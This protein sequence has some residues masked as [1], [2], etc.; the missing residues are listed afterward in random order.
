MPAETI[1]VKIGGEDITIP[2]VANF[3]TLERIWPSIEAFN[4]APNGIQQV[5]AACALFAMALLETKPELNVAVIKSKLRINA[6]DGTDERP[7]LLEGVDK[8]LMASGLIQP[9][10]AEPAVDADQNSTATG[11]IS[12]Q[13]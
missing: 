4:A 3:A 10:E 6:N 9:G 2:A 7:G 11:N 1:T 13:S 12:S 8:L 5:G